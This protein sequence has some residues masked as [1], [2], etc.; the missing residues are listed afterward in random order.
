[1]FIKKISDVGKERVKAG[2]RC[3]RQVLIGPNE[4]PH[5]SMRRFV[6]DTGGEIP[7]HTNTVEHEQYVLKGRA[8]IGIGDKKF[9]VKTG[10][11]VYIPAGE[12]H[13]YKTV[14]EEPFIFLCVVPNEEDIMKMV[15]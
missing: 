4:A 13:W 3:Y 9:T 8:Q 6:I 5:F 2:T 11:V 14:G 10:D 1:M 7:N 15:K 12:A